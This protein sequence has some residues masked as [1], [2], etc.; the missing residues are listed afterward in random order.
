[1]KY[2]AILTLALLLSVCSTTGTI[3]EEDFTVSLKSPRISAGTFEAQFEKL[4]NIGD[5][6]NIDVNVE[7]YPLEDAVCLQYRLDFM[8]YYQFWSREG[9][10]AYISA[11][12]Q[13]KED[14]TL[15]NLNPKGSKKTKRQYG[16]VEGY[17]IWQ[18]AAY[19]VRAYAKTDIELGYYM[20]DVSR[21]RAAFFTLYQREAVFIDEM[22]KNEKRT[23][24]N[25]T[26]YLTRAKADE[27]AEFFD[28]NFLR[29]LDSSKIEVPYTDM[30]L[31]SY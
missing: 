8:T 10:A 2:T 29:S 28:Q 5:L 14:Y 12:D 7:Y 20:R 22:S 30:E 11:L 19:T 26:M 13:Y 21:N 1:M 6:R 9:R 27:L 18:A 4:V 16:K 23:A 25:M 31:D 17:L 15:R 24:N 3:K